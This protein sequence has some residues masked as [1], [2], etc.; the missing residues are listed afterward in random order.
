MI[1]KPY[2]ISYSLEYFWKTTIYTMTFHAKQYFVYQLLK[3]EKINEKLQH[4]NLLAIIL[5]W[6]K[7]NFSM[8]N[9]IIFP[10]P[11]LEIDIDKYNREYMA[12]SEVSV[13]STYILHHWLSYTYHFNCYA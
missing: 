1:I 7:A 10:D 8:S 12:Q 11:E 3:R 2:T 13:T 4:W 5:C 9:F 6:I